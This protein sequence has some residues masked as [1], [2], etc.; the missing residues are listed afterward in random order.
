MEARIS[1]FL[2]FSVAFGLAAA[3]WVVG[4]EIGAIGRVAAA[5]GCVACAVAPRA[6]IEGG[7]VIGRAVLG[8]ILFGGAVGGGADHDV[9]ALRERVSE[10]RVRGVVQGRVVEAP[11]PLRKGWGVSIEV[12]A[13][14]GSAVEPA[15]ILRLFVPPDRLETPNPPLPGDRVRVFAQLEPY[16]A[17]KFPG[18]NARRDR[19]A[20]RGVAVRGVAEDT[21]EVTGRFGGFYEAMARRLASRRVAY[22][23]DLYRRASSPSVSYAA[24]MTAGA[25]GLLSDEQTEPFRRTGTGHLLAISGLH[26]GILAA[27]LWRAF[28]YL[29]GLAPALLRRWGRR[30]VCA[31]PVLGVLGAYVWAIGAPVSAVR[32]FVM[33]AAVV[34]ALA[35]ARPVDSLHGLGAAAVVLIAD[36]PARVC[37]LGFQLS[38]AATGAI[39]WFLE[40]RPRSLRPDPTGAEPESRFERWRRRGGLAAGVSLSATLATWPVLLAWHGWVP[41]DAVWVNLVVTPVVSALLVPVL[42][43]GAAVA[44]VAPTV[45]VAVLE[46]GG[47]AMA[48][49]AA[50]LRW[51]AARPP[52]ALVLGRLPA[53]AALGTGVG[54][55][56]WIGSRGRWRP[57]V[58]GAVAV[59]L[60]V[61]PAR[62]LAPGPDALRVHFIPVGQG[63]A[64]LVEFPGGRTMLVDAGGSA[65]GSDP[66]RR[67]V[68]PYL[69]RLG[70]ARLDW[71][72]GTHADVDHIGG[73]PAVAERLRPHSFLFDPDA[74]PRMERLARLA[75][76]R[77]TEREPV[78]GRRSWR[79]GGVSVRMLRPE[80]ETD[81]RDN[82]RSLVTILEYGGRRVV[83]PADIEAE[84]ERRMRQRLP[85]SAAVVKVP[86]HGS[87]TS[88]TPAFLDRLRAEVAVV[89]AGRY[90]PYG[91]PHPTVERRYRRRDIDWLETARHGLV[92]LRI[93]SDG[94]WSV[95]AVRPSAG[96]TDGVAR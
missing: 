30:R 14:D 69:R 80:V 39:L 24:A 11:E 56:L 43:G 15:S 17:R 75:A 16:P 58:T 4:P 48:G 86:H 84:T 93:S 81:T 12:T 33:V 3:G 87:N 78:T 71:I 82:D 66:G 40:R 64:T 45:G 55:F 18:L 36:D 73:M 28:G 68:A 91:H 95:R 92:R 62:G 50:V 41:V 51:I 44:F 52:Y 32:A 63:D 89:S 1:P 34:G 67:V 49:C 9:E 70:I 37:T 57:I 53:L 83:L 2:V 90:N 27:M 96:S 77:R 72:V 46:V 65:F 42:F 38:F 29:A 6:D 31:G 22:L 13:V 25:R 19:M 26:L 7:R 54:V 85:E 10:E 5:M 74:G 23:Q 94:N 8:G 59:A 79:V 21:V 76:A 88:S 35:V 60:G 20:R 47:E 61:L